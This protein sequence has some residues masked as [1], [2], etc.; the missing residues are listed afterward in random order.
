LRFTQ[1]AITTHS[2]SPSISTSLHY[3][4]PGNVFIKWE[5]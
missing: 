3:P 2:S 1:F 5:L 4:F